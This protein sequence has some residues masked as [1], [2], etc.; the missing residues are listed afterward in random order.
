MCTVTT[1]HKRLL[2]VRLGVV[3]VQQ[4]VLGLRWYTTDKGIVDTADCFPESS[5][6]KSTSVFANVTF[7]TCRKVDIV[8]PTAFKCHLQKKKILDGFIFFID[9]INRDISVVSTRHRQK[10]T[11][12]CTNYIGII[13]FFIQSRYRSA[14]TVLEGHHQNQQ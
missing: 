14:E 5:K 1:V 2:P 8:Q 13:T 3:L 12:K 11:K 4:H 7:R 9:T 10:T 6:N